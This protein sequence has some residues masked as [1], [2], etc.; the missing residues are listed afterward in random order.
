MQT[1]LHV[2]NAAIARLLLRVTALEVF[3][4]FALVGRGAIQAAIELR[5]RSTRSDE[6]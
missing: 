3:F 5:H 6:L 4:F 1:V 2:L